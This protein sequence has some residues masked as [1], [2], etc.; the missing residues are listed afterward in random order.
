[1]GNLI[2]QGSNLCSKRVEKAIQSCRL[3]SFVSATQTCTEKLF[4]GK[5]QAP[6]EFG[7]SWATFSKTE[8]SCSTPHTRAT[9]PISELPA[10]IFLIFNV[11]YSQKP[12]PKPDLM[13]MCVCTF[14]K[15]FA[16]ETLPLIPLDIV[17]SVPC[18]L[19]TV[20]SRSRTAS[21]LRRCSCLDVLQ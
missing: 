11:C 21:F 14:L 1:M 18:T 2:H 7:Q 16:V 20:S 3:M 17:P 6:S 12:R 10:I 4:M 9:G 8:E 19:A 15:V 13:A 5:K